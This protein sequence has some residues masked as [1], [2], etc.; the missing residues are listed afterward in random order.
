MDTKKNVRHTVGI[1]LALVVGLMIGELAPTGAAHA[2]SPVI[3]ESLT[4]YTGQALV[5]SAPE[6]LKRVAVGDGKMIQV[7][8]LGTREMVLIANKPGDTSLQ[9]WLTDGTQRSVAVHIVVGNTDQVSDLVRQ[10]L[11]D[12]RA[13]LRPQGVMVVEIGH[14]RAHFEAAF[15]R[16]QVH[17]LPVSAGE[18]AVF[19]VEAAA[20]EALA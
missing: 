15:P 10:L 7:K 2:E 1:F 20:L 14:E 4:M 11:R 6:S 16:L 3:P 5:Q 18:D 19:L 8:V 13:R 9:L 17:W 12:A